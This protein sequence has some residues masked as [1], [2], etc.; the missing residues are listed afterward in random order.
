MGQYHRLVAQKEGR[1]EI[2]SPDEL[3]MNLKLCEIISSPADV[4]GQE[5]Y[6]FLPV[7]LW[8]LLRTDASGKIEIAGRWAG[9]RV[10]IWGHC[11]TRKDLPPGTTSWKRDGKYVAFEGEEIAGEMLAAAAAGIDTQIPDGYVAVCEE[12]GEK[13]HLVPGDI[14]TDPAPLLSIA[15]LM[16]LLAGSGDNRG[17]GDPLP[18]VDIRDVGEEGV[19]KWAHGVA[20]RTARRCARSQ[21]GLFH[22]TF[23]E[24]VYQDGWYLSRKIIGRWAGRTVY[25]D[26]AERQGAKQDITPIVAPIA[27]IEMGDVVAK[28]KRFLSPDLVL[29]AGGRGRAF[30]SVP[31][32]QRRQAGNK[33]N[34]IKSSDVLALELYP[35]TFVK[36]GYA[37]VPTLVNF[38]DGTIMLLSGRTK[39]E[40]VRY[41]GG[42]LLLLSG[43]VS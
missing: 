17:G 40:I 26:K 18:Y 32:A 12:R 41:S 10:G 43:G 16:F 21:E 6:A 3:G 7:L 30:V 22:H 13:V 28:K 29:V 15:G 36:P 37:S 24:L 38:P 5:V 34:G 42:V 20:K 25:I 31:D 9:W 8:N 27:D 33:A 23:A 39:K 11:T 14:T 19:V 2:V 35:S 4:G 1:T